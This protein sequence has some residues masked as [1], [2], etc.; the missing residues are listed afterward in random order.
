VKKVLTVDDVS[1]F[2]LR[3]QWMRYSLEKY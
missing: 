1:S 3:R 2:E